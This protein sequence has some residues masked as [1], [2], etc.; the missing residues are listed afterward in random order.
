MAQ[1]AGDWDLTPYFD[2]LGGGEYRAFRSDFDREVRALEREALALGGIEPESLEGWRALMLRLEDATARSGHLA[3]YLGCLGA[4]DS[5]DAE[6]QRETASAAESRAQL[7]KVYVLLRAALREIDDSLF[8][9][10]LEGEAL[11]G[12]RYFLERLRYSA[13]QSMSAELELLATELGVTGISAWG[14]LYDR[15]SGTLDFELAVPGRAAQRLPVSA[16]RSLLDDPDPAVRRAALEGSNR[17]WQSVA[18]VAAA[19]LNSIAGVRHTLYARRGVEHFLDAATFDAGIERTTLDTLLGVVRERSEVARRYLRRKAGLIGRERL[20]FQDLT[21]PLPLQRRAGIGWDEARERVMSAFEGFAPELAR[22]AE[23]AFEGRWI[24]HTQREGKRPGGFC[25]TSHVLGESRIFLTYGE[26]LGDLSTLA[27][28][29]GH[30]FHGWVMRDLR[31]WLRRSPMT[32]AETASTFA[33]QLMIDAVLEDPNSTAEE[34]A[35]VLDSRMQDAATFLLNIPMR[36]VFE[37]TLYE[38]RQKGELGVERLC[39]L[40]LAAQRECY[41]DALAEDELDPLFWASKLHFYIT[42]ISFYNFPYTFGY[43]FSLGLRARAK[44]EG[45]DFVPRY[46]HLLRHTG[47]AA[48]EAVALETLGIDLASAEFWHASIDQV[49]EYAARFDAEMDARG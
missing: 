31:S 36:F 13:Q 34:R 8:E 20:G 3:S 35:L 6:V 22:F 12:C 26:T 47:S 43:L 29:L 46:V 4:A 48:A 10:L 49:E 42:G 45:P 33:E 32:L 18:D 9:A 38:E 41:G 37:R 1:A 27:H 21:A 44:K 40:M 30:A 15:I 28:E 17:A 11:L 14:R 2:S 7:E 39:E 16:V 19:C 23:R 5:R 24:D 25:S